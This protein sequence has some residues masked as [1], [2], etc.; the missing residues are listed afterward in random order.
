MGASYAPSC[1]PHLGAPSRRRY[2]KALVLPVLQPLWEAKKTEQGS[3]TRSRIEIVLGAGLQS[4][5]A[6]SSPISLLV[7]A[8]PHEEAIQEV[9]LSPAEVI[10]KMTDDILHTRGRPSLVSG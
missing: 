5:K 1:L 8:E 10:G 9:F 4:L 2:D 6:R 3:R 7:D